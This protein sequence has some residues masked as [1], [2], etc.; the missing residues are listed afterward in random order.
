[1]TIPIGLCDRNCVIVQPK[2]ARCTL[3]KEILDLLNKE[4]V[5]GSAMVEL[6]YK[7]DENHKCFKKIRR[8]LRY[9]SNFFHKHTHIYIYV[10]TLTSITTLLA[11]HMQ[12][13]Q[14]FLRVLLAYG[15]LCLECLEHLI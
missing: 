4:S 5:S 14:R 12:G 9:D 6:V 11:L 15:M 3:N 8:S 10:W 7:L 13:N 2:R 1:M